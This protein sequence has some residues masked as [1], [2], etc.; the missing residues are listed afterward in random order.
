MPDGGL[1]IALISL[2][3]LVR[4]EDMELG[5][6][7]DTGG[8]VKYVVELARALAERDDVRRVDLVT[9]QVH[10]G[11]LSDDYARVVEPLG[12]KAAIHRIA[13]GPRRYLRKESLWPYMAHFVDR[14]IP[15][16]RRHGGF[17]DVLHGHYADGGYGGA[18]LARLLG[19]PFVFTGHSL[20]RIK[21]QRL[22]DRGGQP[23][24]LEERYTFSRRIEAEEMAL[25]TASLVVAST[26]QEVEEQYEL[27][28]HY[29]PERMEIIPPGVDLD[30][31]EPPDG[32]EHRSAV[33][34][35]VDRFLAEPDK[36]FILAI[37]RPD[38]RKNLEALVEV[39]GRSRELRELAN[40]VLVLGS[41]DDIRDMPKAQRKVLQRILV[42]I[43]AHDLYGKVAYPKSHLAEE[44]PL[45]YRLAAARRGMFVN[46]AWTE[47]FGLT[48]LEAAASGLPVV[49]TNDGGPRDILANCECGLL[50]D[51]RDPQN[52]EDALV[53][54]LS[55]DRQWDE[56]SG[57]GA[58]GTRRHYSWARHAERYVRDL[59]EIRAAFEPPVSDL[60]GGR[61]R[62]PDFD[63]LLIT[64]VDNTLTG[65]D[66]ALRDLLRVV[67]DGAPR[68][69]FGIATGRSFGKALEILEAHDIP[70]PD[71]LITGV[72][73]E[74]HYGE[75]LIPDRSW[76]RQIDFAW[77]PDRVREVL[78]GF[79][80]VFPQEPEEQSRWKVSYQLDPEEA[81]DLAALKTALREAGLRVKTTLSHG[82]YLDV[83]PARAGSGLCIR[84]IALKW[85][86][87][88]EQILVAG[89]SGNDEGMLSGGTLGVVVGNYS[90]ELEPLREHPRVYFAEGEH[91]LGILEGMEHY[92]FLG[93]ISIPADPGDPAGE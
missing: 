47:P 2:H 58:R 92:N 26:R 33:K 36:P 88:L 72:G 55:D 23:A 13:F 38:E 49:A 60:A 22:L 48:L 19:I 91:A 25:E 75:E 11:R 29:V 32:R 4:G 8:Q 90:A 74:V 34:G 40:L 30:A 85:D 62:L 81:P 56:W 35:A 1:Y 17:P 87:P 28:D 84:H 53:R 51:P 67:R 15:H 70:R 12:P 63:R 79:E 7:A 45:I 64:D 71:V 9:R 77:E 18:Q 27:Y 44:V 73:T 54:V 57:N 69:G 78:G 5:R 80:G 31:F 68:M 50:I 76:Q 42:L 3:G 89:D 86:F 93:H 21:E 59:R 14:A 61:R 82:I 10:D 16:F 52:I 46:P 6:D 65:D 66:R 43:D 20:G 39:Y 37:A 24:K 83:I 41:R